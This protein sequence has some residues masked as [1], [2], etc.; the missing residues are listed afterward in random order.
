MM[1]AVFKTAQ[2]GAAT[3]IYVATSPELEGIG[4]QYFD[5]CQ[6][7]ILYAPHALDEKNAE[8]LWKLSEDMTSKFL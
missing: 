1:K 2:Q 8:R 4:G 7:A 3:T 5:D 6:K